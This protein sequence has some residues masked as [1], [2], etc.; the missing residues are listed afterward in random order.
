M[1]SKFDKIIRQDK[2]VL[3][4]FFADW[5]G[6]CKVMNPIIKEV[7]EIIGDDATI[8]KVNV[9]NNQALARK[10]QIRGVPTFIIFKNGDV[11]WQQSGIID[12]NKLVDIIKSFG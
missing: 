2:P 9:D 3:V 7:K 11:Q 4:D 8:L 5:C 10:Y 1:M 6:P 12:K